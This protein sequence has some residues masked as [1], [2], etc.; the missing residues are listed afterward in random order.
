MTVSSSR[1]EARVSDVKQSLTSK[2]ELAE[3]VLEAHR[4]KARAPLQAG[5]AMP[6]IL[7]LDQLIAVGRAA[8]EDEDPM[9]MLEAHGEFVEAGL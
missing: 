8:L 1:T 4:A 3:R 2:T 6:A 9:E 5:V 7:F